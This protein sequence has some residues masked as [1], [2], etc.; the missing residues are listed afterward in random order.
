MLFYILE[1]LIQEE[2]FAI[3]L[4]DDLIINNPSCNSQL[5]NVMMNTNVPSLE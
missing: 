2:S 3:V 5:I 1:H 4:A